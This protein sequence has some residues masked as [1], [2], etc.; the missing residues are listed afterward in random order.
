MPDLKVPVSFE[1]F[2][3]QT[4]QGRTN[5][6]RTADRLN[7]WHPDYFSVTYGAGG[8]TRDRTF[9]TIA[10]L[11]AEGLPA[12][13]HFSMGTDSE[14]SVQQTLI[15]YQQMGIRRIVALR[16]DIPSGLGTA[17]RAV[18]YAVDLV[19]L[20]R[21][22][23]PD[24]FDILVACYP[25]MHPDAGSP[26]QDLKHFAD[27]VSA[28]ASAAITQYFYNADAYF[29]FVARAQQ[30]GVEIPIIPGIMPI[31][32]YTN[33]VRFSDACG[34]EIPRWI[35]KHLEAYQ[36]DEASL[37]AFGCD[38]VSTLCERLL[39]EGA[40]GIHFYTLNRAVPT[41]NIL[42]RL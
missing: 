9:E 7:A 21:E 14:A 10:T 41:L 23:F 3:P 15:A 2:P 38:V 36:N 31:T 16:G 8:S 19:R 35:R 30:A 11:S 6:L 25:E 24:S 29:D 32:N 27:K 12:T 4:E 26:E 37:A 28:G 22:Q 18:R 13:P 40:P 5:L 42:E 20:I 17:K 1:F 39:A 33:L 34:A